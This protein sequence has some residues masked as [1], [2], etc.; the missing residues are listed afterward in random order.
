VGRCQ[1]TRP[2]KT[3]DRRPKRGQQQ[4]RNRTCAAS[5]ELNPH[6]SRETR[7]TQSSYYR[8]VLISSKL[9]LCHHASSDN[10]YPRTPEHRV[11][12][13]SLPDLQLSTL[14]PPSIVGAGLVGATAALALARLPNVTITVYERSPEPREVGAWIAMNVSGK[15]TPSPFPHSVLT[16]SRPSSLGQ[17]PPRLQS[18][19]R[20]HVP[21]RDGHQ[22]P[23]LAHR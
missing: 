8:I 4:W 21:R 7:K 2:R 17:H 16:S 11:S 6:P 10:Q 3:D 20:H 19:A 12:P 23:P 18:A 22:P 9:H 13:V 14:T 15:R 1:S 5:A